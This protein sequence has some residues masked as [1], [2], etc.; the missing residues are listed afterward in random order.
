[1]EWIP[2]DAK[3]T[4]KVTFLPNEK[5]S[6]VLLFLSCHKERETECNKQRERERVDE[7]HTISIIVIAI[8]VTFNEYIYI[9]IAV[10]QGYEKYD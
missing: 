2:T 1:V 10:Q 3:D 4:N 7:S 5:Q 8:S 9:D 6:C